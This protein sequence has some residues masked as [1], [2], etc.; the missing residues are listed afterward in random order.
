MAKRNVKNKKPAAEYVKV[1]GQVYEKL[2]PGTVNIELD[3]SSLSKEELKSIERL[4]KEGGFVNKQEFI[5][6][7]LRAKFEVMKL[8]ELINKKP[9]PVKKK[10]SKNARKN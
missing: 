10:A 5:R 1:N 2:D 4:T 7:V 9:K 8:Q 3:L 6:H